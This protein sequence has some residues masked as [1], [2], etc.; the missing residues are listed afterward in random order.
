M[1]AILPETFKT[2]KPPY[3]RPC[4][5]KYHVWTPGMATCYL[6]DV[7][8]LKKCLNQVRKKKNHAMCVWEHKY[9]YCTIE[10]GYVCTEYMSQ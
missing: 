2:Y 10:M 4:M 5:P 8:F 6:A 3:C 9:L 1:L 7:N